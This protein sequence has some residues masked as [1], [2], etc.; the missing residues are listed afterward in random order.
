MKR[1]VAPTMTSPVR[2]GFLDAPW[3]QVHYREAGSGPP[4]L[5]LHKTSMSGVAWAPFLPRLAGQFRVIALDTP[6]Y[7]DSARP[8]G[9]PDFAFY[10]DAVLLAMDA[11]GLAEAAVMGD[12]TGA[13]LAV[14]VAARIPDRV[15][16]LVLSNPPVLSPEEAEGLRQRPGARALDPAGEYLLLTWQRTAGRRHS[17]EL[18]YWDTVEQLRAFPANIWALKALADA[19]MPSLLAAVRCPVLVLYNPQDGVLRSRPAL[20]AA[21]PAARV[22]VPPVQTLDHFAEDPA[23][24]DLVLAFLSAPDPARVP[25]PPGWS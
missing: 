7:G 14:G 16:R 3:G 8:P 21:L 25:V 24:L 1:S 2:R 23:V 18:A 19:P 4:L 17:L 5:L 6:G 12:H 13:A 20:E 11:L 10:V 15:T 9:Q 22:A